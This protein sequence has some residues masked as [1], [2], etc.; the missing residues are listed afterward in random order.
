MS[1]PDMYHVCRRYV[2]RPVRLTLRGGRSHVGEVTRVSRSHVWVRPLGNQRGF[3]YGFYG[4]P[5]G[6]FGVPFALGAITG[7]ALAAA[8]FW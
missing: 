2:G 5:Y 1:G 6:G 4:Y 7:V 8:F 3:N